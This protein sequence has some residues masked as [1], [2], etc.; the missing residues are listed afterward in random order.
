M[1]SESLVVPFAL[2]RKRALLRS[3]NVSWTTFWDRTIF[4][5]VRSGVVGDRLRCIVCSAEEG[6]EYP[7]ATGWAARG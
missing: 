6:C 3:G 7:A 1:P 5:K 2:A 4:A